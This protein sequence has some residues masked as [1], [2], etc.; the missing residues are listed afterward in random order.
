MRTSIRH[1]DA[2]SAAP[3]R[4][5]RERHA[6]RRPASGC[7]GRPRVVGKSFYVGDERV[8]LRGVSYGTF[9]ARADG[10]Q[11]PETATVEADLASM[12]SSGVNVLRTYTVPPWWLLDAASRQGL[13]VLVGIPWEQHVAFL[14]K[15]STRRSIEAAVRDG[16]R[17]CAGHT[18]VLG[19]T[20]GNEIPAPT[21]RW[22]GRH[23]VERFIERLYRAAKEE[24]PEGLVTYVNYP[25]TEYLQLPF[26]DF[27][28][29]NVY[30]E[31]QQNLEAYIARL[32]TTAE[33]R[34]LVMA[35]IGLDSR[36]NGEAEQ[37]HAIAWQ[38]DTVFG[39][40]CA[41]AFVFSWTD[42][43]HRG[44]YDIDDWDFG[45]VARDRRPKEALEAVAEAFERVERGPGEGAPRISVVVCTYNGARWLDGCFDALS[46]VEYPNFEVMLVD[47]G[48]TDGSS[49]V[50]ERRGVRVVRSD[51][52]GGLS[53]ARNLGLRAST[54][55]I[56]AYLD[57]DARPEPDWLR[58][59]AH[60]FQTRP[61]GAVGGPNIPP[62]GDGVVADCITE[63]PGGPIHVLVTDEVAEHIPG[64]NMAIRR[65]ALTEI[66]GFDPRFRTAGD[67]VDICWRLQDAG[68]RIGFNASAVVWHHRRC[69]VS[70]YFK[71]QYGYGKAEGLLERKWPDRY[72]RA[73]HLRW[74][75]RV[76]G[77]GAS[78]D[79]ASRRAKI[80]YGRW[81]GRLFQS[82]YDPAQGSLGA[83]LLAMP[84]SYLV[85]AALAGVAALGVL[86]PPLLLALVPLAL[87]LV[88]ITARAGLA[89]SAHAASRRGAGRGWRRWTLTTAL[90][91]AQP[92][93]R[94]AGRLRQGL[95][96]WR[97]RAQRRPAL[98]WARTESFWSE[99]WAPL[100]R[101]VARV[102]VR[103]QPQ[104]QAV[105]CGADF[106]RWDLEVRGG[107]FGV[108]RVLTTVEEHGGGQQLV[109]F[110]IWPRVSRGATVL[111]LLLAGVGVVA[112]EYVAAIP[113]VVL[114]L[115]A[116]LVAAVAMYD[117]AL[118]V[119]L[120]VAGVREGTAA[121]RGRLRVEAPA[122]VS[123]GPTLAPSVQRENG[124][125]PSARTVDVPSEPRTGAS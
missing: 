78:R 58:R 51:Q 68:H 50:A 100:E 98:P 72:N 33:E 65:D 83:A 30:L 87:A 86:W 96:P 21:V 91:V 119:G 85:V 112:A 102:Q 63:S 48:S 88:G 71:Q 107:L 101:R 7:R 32:H 2:R 105:V 64:C 23:R 120:I 94:L 103:T 76:Y 104:A 114:G 43:W 108:A 11:F 57:D 31:S 77:R 5:G 42:E 52:N 118:G 38:L 56:I 22:Y 67:D 106:D 90:H 3:E 19:Y 36:R 73:G 111:T 1:D 18:A 93:A 26:L 123:V 55:E 109:R 4:D 53:A 34:P 54:G 9:R 10:A 121:G 79:R 70:S 17:A 37:A 49:A 75:G 35:E 117:C 124:G 29:F 69:H 81:G 82:I 59:L 95:S 41:G 6:V 97:R 28:S 125:N 45:L 116:V 44:G 40:G 25:T 14:D 27:A 66:G 39:S 20:V 113:A 24:D 89:A 60:T 61:Y 110:R 84:E 62:R 122:A 15:R 16:V 80:N 99:Q 8:N 13:R 92:V 46:R 115:A 74:A 47:D 12:A